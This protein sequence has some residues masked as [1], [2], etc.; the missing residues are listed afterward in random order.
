M[1]YAVIVREPYLLELFNVYVQLGAKF[2]F[3]LRKGRYLSCE[4]VR[5]G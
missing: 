5:F 1:V 3:R 2:C 4:L